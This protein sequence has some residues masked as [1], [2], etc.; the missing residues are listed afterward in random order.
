MISVVLY[1]RN[2]SYGYNLHKRAVLSLNCIAEALDDP[3]DEIIFV[4]YNTPDDLP[5]FPEAIGD[6]LTERACKLTRVLRV[7]E[8][9]HARFAGKTHLKALESPSRNAAVRRSN[10]RN[11]WI[12]S[13][14]TDMVF[15]TRNG[16]SLSSV[17][18]N[19][20]DGFYH[21]T[22]FELP[23]ILWETLN[24]LN[25]TDCI[26]TIARWGERL[27]LQ[28]VVYGSPITLFDGP[29]DFQLILRDDAFRID[30]FDERMLLGWHVDTNI[31]RR[32]EILRGEPVKSA[33]D[34]IL[35]FHCDHN[36]ETTP[37]H[38]HSAPQNDWGR[39]VTEVTTAGIPEQ[40]DSWGLAGDTLE[41]FHLGTLAGAPAILE[42][43]LPPMPQPFYITS[44]E[45][46]FFQD[47]RYD[48]EHVV[49]YVAN[50]I[51]ALP[52]HWNVAYAGCR[53]KMFAAFRSLW[54]ALG[55][56]GKILVTDQIS[57]R[58]LALR[59]DG[60]V[61][62]APESE[63]HARADLFV[64]EVGASR[65]D[66]LPAPSGAR[67]APADG[68]RMLSQEEYHAF[69]LLHRAYVRAVDAERRAGR[70]ARRFVL[71]N[72]Q[73][74][75]SESLVQS[76]VGA[77]WTPIA[78]HVRHG[79]VLPDPFAMPSIDAVAWL[80]SNLSGKWRPQR[81]LL[82]D[83]ARKV[84]DGADVAGLKAYTNV[85]SDLISAFQQRGAAEALRT[86]PDRL[87]K[88]IDEMRARRPS[89]KF[90]RAGVAMTEVAAPDR[91]L[92]RIMAIEDFD[93]PDWGRCAVRAVGVRPIY[94]IGVRSRFA[95]AGA[96]LVYT[97][98]SCGM[99]DKTT[100]L[101]Q[102][103]T[104]D[105][106]MMQLLS[107]TVIDWSAGSAIY[108]SSR[109]FAGEPVFDAIV[110]SP[111]S[112]LLAGAQHVPAVLTAVD[113]ALKPGGVC[114]LV[115]DVVAGAPRE[116]AI[117]LRSLQSERLT[118]LLERDVNWR[119]A[120]PLEAVFSARTLDAAVFEGA[121]DVLAGV[122]VVA[123]EIYSLAILVY[124]KTAISTP[125]A[126]KRYYAAYLGSPVAATTPS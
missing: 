112:A 116:N 110:V 78:T 84:A 89:E 61:E 121:D 1:G 55:F 113:Q 77:S 79:F 117:D 44:I 85:F 73:T 57:E 109:P 29:G 100:M 93:D 106:K 68:M 92:S 14:N 123:G 66:D 22:R 52:H 88:L 99:L 34:Q 7:R 83:I 94:E 90:R 33:L 46:R 35:A 81:E 45:P 104:D 102:H 12:L 10:P 16:S 101:L 120:G 30:G 65:D 107:S 32:L 82:G 13:T 118:S 36:R 6:M 43:L 74:N 86:T 72:M 95:W 80:S 24:R 48:P 103:P 17:V 69:Q 71:I 5:T 38:S 15:I 70:T 60:I 54:Q 115:L 31:A 21:T 20:P 4:D 114:V 64:F 9:E 98:E 51:G 67:N 41:D 58:V 119:M 111:K 53:K 25:P 42:R 49:P 40:R 87:A 76:H 19:L 47:L 50:V 39:F 59:S 122:R 75:P 27:Q 11:R 2:D 108:D 105:P 63:V 23:E 62:V 8:A 91:G 124:Q 28:E 18:R 56:R 126:W 125:E 26:A 96:H 3:D 37:A 97:L